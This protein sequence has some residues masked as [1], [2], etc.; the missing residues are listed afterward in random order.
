[1]HLE[2][3]LPSGP[4]LVLRHV[5]VAAVSLNLNPVWSLLHGRMNTTAMN[6]ATC[7]S[8]WRS[9]AIK[10]EARRRIS[11]RTISVDAADEIIIHE[12]VT[13]VGHW[14]AV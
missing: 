9:I 7:A 11:K 10:W 5:N 13:H 1:M 8:S 12:M 14:N 2:S 3:A 4:I 6:M